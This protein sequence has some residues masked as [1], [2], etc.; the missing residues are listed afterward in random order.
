MG[1]F[2]KLFGRKKVDEES[3]V[4]QSEQPK[5]IQKVQRGKYTYEIYRGKD[6]ES[7]KNF[8]MT[9][10]VDKNFYY[11]KVETPEG[12]WGMDIEGL[13]L[14]RLL[15]WQMDIDSAESEGTIIPMSWSMF[16]LRMAAQGTSDNFIAQVECGKC[17][18]KWIDGVRYQNITVVRCPKCKT[19]N[20]VDSRY[21]HLLAP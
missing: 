9:K 10:Q 11:I 1:I 15:P 16:S 8:L 18:N 7:A 5:F 19:R 4:S 13:Y 3:V 20:K 12:T 2:D 14:E 21:I 17:K 6:A